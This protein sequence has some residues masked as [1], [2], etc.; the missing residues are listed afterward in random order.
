M[1]D[2]RFFSAIA[3]Q[4]TEANLTRIE[5]E[6]SLFYP[7][8][9]GGQLGDRGRIGTA[10][11]L[12]VFRGAQG[13][14]VHE[15]SEPVS[16]PSVPVECLIDGVRRLDIAQQHTA[17]HLLSADIF[18]LY[19][20]QTVGF[21]MGE[22]YSTIDIDGGQWDWERS[23]S[24]E[25]TMLEQI[26]ARV[27]V[28]ILDVPKSDI[29]LYPLRKKMSEKIEHL[30]TFRIVK[31]GN[32]DCSLCGGFHVDHLAQIGGVKTLKYE[33]IKSDWTR[34]YF[35]AGFRALA[36]YQKKTRLLHETTL[37]L[38]TSVDELN[39]RIR[40]ILEEH[41]EA[42]KINRKLSENLASVLYNSFRSQKAEEGVKTVVEIMP[43]EEIAKGLSGKL[44]REEN[45]IAFL[46]YERPKGSGYILS[47]T[48]ENWNARSIFQKV[49][50]FLE[51]KGGGTEK[52][53]QGTVEGNISAIKEKC[54]SI[55]K[56]Y[57]SSGGL[58]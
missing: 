39:Y 20:Y 57:F 44:M 50:E 53:V 56:S 7:D 54:E 13:G 15:V 16:D 43:S 29:Y 18:N 38:S 41:L 47:S 6:T 1:Q 58:L 42:K 40:N 11:V 26:M 30:D 34:L 31:I 10:D 9:E 35:V 27:E 5:L 37:S 28:E 12:R 23:E 55:I 46:L 17:Q 8:S 36:D 4:Y 25:R 51:I 24:A 19:G 49:K 52:M 32:I 14:I 22:A 45:T 48:Q 21:A 3:K 2:V 33:R